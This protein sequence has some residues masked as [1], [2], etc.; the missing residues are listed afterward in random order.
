MEEEGDGF[1]GTAGGIEAQI[2]YLSSE[3]SFGVLGWVKDAYQDPY[4]RLQG[5]PDL[6]KKYPSI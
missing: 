6:N 4:P 2:S 3:A 5:V 1:L